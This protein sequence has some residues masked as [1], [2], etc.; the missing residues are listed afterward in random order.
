MSFIDQ[1]ILGGYITNTVIKSFQHY[2]TITQQWN[3]HP[4]GM[5]KIPSRLSCHSMPN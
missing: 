3:E 4:N 2:N 1:I 5:L